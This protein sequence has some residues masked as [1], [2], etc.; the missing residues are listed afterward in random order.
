MFQKIALNT[1][2]FKIFSHYENSQMRI[3][4]LIPS[5]GHNRLLFFKYLLKN[6]IG[7]F[8][9]LHFKYLPSL[10]PVHQYPIPSFFPGFLFAAAPIPLPIPASL[11]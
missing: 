5:Q 3:L 1:L 7:Y 10:S 6:F 9:Y 11:P 8:I 2:S 4:K